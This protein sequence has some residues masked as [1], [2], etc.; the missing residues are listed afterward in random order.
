MYECGQIKTEIR[1]QLL[2]LRDMFSAE[3]WHL[4]QF[5]IYV[6]YMECYATCCLVK[7]EGRK[8]FSQAC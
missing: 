5:M 2:G 3:S 8:L 6:E 1:A 4:H 7:T